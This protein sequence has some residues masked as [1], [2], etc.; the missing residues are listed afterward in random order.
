VGIERLPT[1]ATETLCVIYARYSSDRQDKMRC[2][3]QVRLC[4]DFAGK[5]GWRVLDTY[6]DQGVSGAL[7]RGVR[8]GWTK[9]IT[10]IEDAALPPGVIVLTYTW[11]RWSRDRYEGPIARMEAQR[12]GVDVADCRHGVFGR[13]TTGQIMVTVE[14][15]R[16][17]DFRDEL[18]DSV[19]SALELRRNEGFW[20]GA[21]PYGTRIVRV[22]RGDSTAA[23]LE[24]SPEISVVERIY[25]EL[26]N[27]STPTAIAQQLNREGVPAARGGPWNPSSVRT[28][29]LSTVYVGVISVYN[30]KPTGKNTGYLAA[31]GQ[32]EL[33]P[34]AWGPMIDQDL[35]RRVREKWL[36]RPH[37]EPPRHRK[38]P[39]S[40]LVV[41]GACGKKAHITGGKWPYR[42]Y[43]CG[44]YGFSGC[45][46]GRL[47]RVPLL[48]EA[49]RG[50]LRGLARDRQAVALAARELSLREREEA[51]RR[52]SSRTPLEAQRLELERKAEACFKALEAGSAPQLVNQ[53]LAQI[54]QEI[55][56]VDER[57]AGIGGTV[58]Q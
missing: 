56:D 22:P 49:V 17:A 18:R 30:S 53:R 2:E 28:I 3:D 39:L 35:H 57:L 38:Y 46:N 1:S 7:G 41:C 16:A 43:R 19:R 37:Q 54:E 15:Q 8:A 26:D 47:A 58:Y 6:M 52:A 14:E 32:V 24:P 4:R 5:Q 55:A 48:E 20:T 9:L 29:A 45:G 13:D 12:R 31:R 33:I 21:A 50:W 51:A 25:R 40:G 42:N 44:H 11:N 27:R 36:P 23:S 34:A 10:D